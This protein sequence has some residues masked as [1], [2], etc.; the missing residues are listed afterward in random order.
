MSDIARAWYAVALGDVGDDPVLVG[1][2][3]DDFDAALEL[4]RAAAAEHRRSARV[5]RV[6]ELALVKPPR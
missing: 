5:L 6:L 4:A 3:L 2:P 1:Q